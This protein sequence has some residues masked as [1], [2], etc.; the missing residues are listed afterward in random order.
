MRVAATFPAGS[1][2]PIVYPAAVVAD[3]QV[4]AARRLLAFLREPEAQAV[5]RRHGFGTD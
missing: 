1:H 5:F 4:A 3:G 2:A